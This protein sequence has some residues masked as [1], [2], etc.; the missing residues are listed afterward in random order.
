MHTKYRRDEADNNQTTV[1]SQRI[2]RVH[3]VTVTVI[4]RSEQTSQEK[5]KLIEW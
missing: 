3:S 1:T 2:V 4:L 5:L